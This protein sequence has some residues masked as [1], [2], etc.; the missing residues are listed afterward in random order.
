MNVVN[1]TRSLSRSWRPLLALA[2][3]GLLSSCAVGPNYKRPD[4]AVPP[5]YKG[6][7]SANAATAGTIPAAWW[8]LFDDP[9]LAKLSSDALAANLSIQAAMARV[10]QA[11]EATRSSAGNF[12]PAISLSPSIRRSGSASGVSTSYSLPLQLGYE[13]DVWGRLRRQYEASQQSELASADDYEFVRQTT[14]ASVAQ[15]YFS[16]RFYDREI[17]LFEEALDLYRKQLDLTNTK[18]K[19]GLAP[20]TDLLQAQTQVNSATNQ[21]IEVR[22]S[23][24]KQEHALAILLGRPPAE[25][26]LPTQPL[27]TPI[28]AVPVGLPANLLNRRPD[29]A[30]S[31]HELAA[32]NA[33]IGVATADFFPSFGLNG[34]AGFDINSAS[35]LTDWANRVWSLVPGA[36]LP[37]FQG[38]QLV[39]ARN[40]AK[41]RYRELVA[42]YRAA[43][44]T[45]FRDVEDSLSDLQLLSEK[46]GS[47]TAT[48]ESAREY[49]RLTQLQYNQ[50]LTTYLQVI[51]ANQTL[52]NNEL[53]AAQAHLDRLNATVLLIKALGGGWDGVP[54]TEQHR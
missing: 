52:L 38:G 10:D 20:Q 37:I 25:V 40:R 15:A 47:L 41:A 43:V 21:L 34:S 9:E 30:E 27:T 8:T 2:G 24:S 17:S 4:L 23:R 6:V 33:D 36:D 31:E 19:A 1:V 13:L 45:A 46:A 7:A 29:V 16:I 50:G 11:R 32:A 26:A 51:D 54:V 35:H 53:S 22:R 49:S 44:L 42:N 14:L 3:G 39:A 28:P 18:Y 5:V 48:I 12:F